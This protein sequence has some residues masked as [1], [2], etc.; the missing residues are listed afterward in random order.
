[1]KRPT[2]QPVLRIGRNAIA[3][4][5]LVL[6]SALTWFVTAASTGIGLVIAGVQLVFGTGWALIAGGIAALAV[7]WFISRGIGRG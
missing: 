5:V 2:L 3:L 4:L 1:M 6:V 7:S